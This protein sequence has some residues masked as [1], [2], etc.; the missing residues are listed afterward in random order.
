MRSLRGVKGIF[1]ASLT[2]SLLLHVRLIPLG[3]AQTQVKVV[4]PDDPM[5]RRALKRRSRLNQRTDFN[6][7]PLTEPLPLS[8]LR[9]T[10]CELFL[11]NLKSRLET[12]R[13]IYQNDPERMYS[14]AQYALDLY[15]HGQLYQVR[16]RVHQKN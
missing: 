6:G 8:V 9:T 15:S 13:Q 7:Y 4:G 14:R 1:I 12:T 11:G 3:V 16:H 5:M 10:S 2:V